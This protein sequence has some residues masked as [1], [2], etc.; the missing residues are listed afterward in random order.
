MTPSSRELSK[1]SKA[2]AGYESANNRSCKPAA[3]AAL[4]CSSS[5]VQNPS[6]PESRWSRRAAAMCTKSGECLRTASETTPAN[7]SFGWK[8]ANRAEVSAYTSGIFSGSPFPQDRVRPLFPR[9]LLGLPYLGHD[10][11]PFRVNRLRRRNQKGIGPSISQNT[12][13]F[14]LPRAIQQLACFLVQHL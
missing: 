7:S 12:K 14:P 1:Q 5:H 10:L 8:N 11:R 9:S 4:D 13:S 6:I 2:T 3:L